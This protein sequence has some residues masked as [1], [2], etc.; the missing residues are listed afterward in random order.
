MLC[1][2]KGCELGEAALRAWFGF[3]LEG[4][5]SADQIDPFKVA[6]YGFRTAD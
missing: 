6:M 4:D 2:L 1:R 5:T 3:V